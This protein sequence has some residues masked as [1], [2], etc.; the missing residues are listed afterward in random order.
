M[1]T[2]ITLA[3]RHKF[4]THHQANQDLMFF[5]PARRKICRPLIRRNYRS[6]AVTAFKNHSSKK[7]ILKLLGQNLCKEVSSL[8]STKSKSALAQPPK[9]ISNI[10][11][12]VNGLMADMECRAPIL[13]SLLKWASKTQRP[14]GNTKLVLSMITSMLCKHRKSSVCQLQRIVSLIL[15]AGHSS[16]QVP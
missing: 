5:T 9:K 1:S 13:L 14:R 15:Y 8:C 16:K 7:A 11:G 4:S 10:S 6:F 3:Y 2:K 12:V